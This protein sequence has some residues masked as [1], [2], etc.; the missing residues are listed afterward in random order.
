MKLSLA[1]APLFAVST[2]AFVPVSRQNIARPAT[3]LADDLFGEGPGGSKTKEMSKALPF[4]PRPKMLDGTLPADF[5][6]E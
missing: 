1:L 5:G 4:V 3:S 2:S 6:F